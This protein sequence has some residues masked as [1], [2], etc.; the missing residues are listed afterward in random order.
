MADN[1]TITAGTG[2]T[3]AADEVTDGTLGTVKVQYVKL[4][5]GTLNGVDKATIKASNTAPINTDTALVVAVHPLSTNANVQADPSGITG[6]YGAP[7]VLVDQYSG[8]K[9]VAASQTGAVLG[10]TGAQYD[11][12][13]GILIIPATASAGAVSIADGNGAA[14][15]IFAGGGTTALADLK[16]FM[17]PVGAFCIASTTPGWKVTTGTNVSVVGIGKFT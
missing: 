9:T 2:T 17:V 4:M 13:A 8:Y 14:I 1:V 16:P 7:T 10:A 12:L 6:H 3:V 15:T 5:D 11:Y